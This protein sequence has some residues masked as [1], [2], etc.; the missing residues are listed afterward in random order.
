MMTTIKRKLLARYKN[1]NYTVRLYEDGTKIK[2]TLDDEFQA[3]F[4]DSV[5]LKITDYCDVNCPMCHES[6]SVNGRHADLN[7]P[8]LDTFRA[9]TELA[10]GGGN[11]LSHPNLAKFLA[12]MKNRG[13]ICNLT[14]NERHLLQNRQLLQDMFAERLI[15][16]LGIS[17]NT[18]DLQ[19]LEFAQRNKT[20]VLHAICGILDEQR[21]VKLYNKDLNILLLGYKDFG[22][23]KAYRNKA[24]DDN[25]DWLKSNALDLAE[26]FKTVCFD[27]LALA[28]LDM[29]NQ[30]PKPLFEQS[31]M[32]DDG[33]SSMYVDLV[34]REFAVSSV[35]DE[36]Y[37]LPD[38][39]KQAFDII[40][41]QQA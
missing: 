20:V 35:S 34:N 12:R 3:D 19:T 18:Y 16:G 5:D 23:G 32:G 28:Q 21:A 31:Y 33:T 14:V 8:F 41:K 6:S 39:V 9:G 11:P 22:R 10:I 25:I 30:L 4:P 37:P 1:G 38:T 7:V 2:S 29:R 24:V 15:W 27:N 13:V 36:R 26:K 40:K 17:L